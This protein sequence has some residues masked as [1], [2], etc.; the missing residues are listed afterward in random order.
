MKADG[1][2]IISSA[3]RHLVEALNIFEH[4]RELNVARVELVRGERVEHECIVGVRRMRDGD[5]A[6]FDCSGHV[7]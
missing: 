3:P 6:C 2:H 1:R 7:D 4:M 5:G